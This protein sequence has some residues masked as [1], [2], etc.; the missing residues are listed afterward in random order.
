MS[1]GINGQPASATKQLDG[2][3]RQKASVLSLATIEALQ[4][5]AVLREAQGTESRPQCA[6][7]LVSAGQK[8]AERT[9]RIADEDRIVR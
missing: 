1:L 7:R 5:D 6:A 4:F 9:G 3:A 2:P 8:F